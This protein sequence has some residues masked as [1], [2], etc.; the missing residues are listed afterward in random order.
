[1]ASDCNKNMIEAYDIGYYDD[2]CGFIEYIGMYN[3]RY[4][5]DSLFSTVFIDQ[6]DIERDCPKIGCLKILMVQKLIS[7]F[8]TVV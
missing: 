8:K 6:E 4:S 7:H 1:M 3:Q 5:W 2:S